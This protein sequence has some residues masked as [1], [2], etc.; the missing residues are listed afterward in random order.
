M[1]NR[2]TDGEE[3]PPMVIPAHGVFAKFADG[4][5]Y[6]V[7]CWKVT[8]RRIEDEDEVWYTTDVEGMIITM[9]SHLLSEVTAFGSFKEYLY[10]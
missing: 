10:E 3:L 4:N 7:V 2:L 5:M 9:D 6:P 1:N 8:N